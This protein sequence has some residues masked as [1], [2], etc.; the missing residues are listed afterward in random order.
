MNIIKPKHTVLQYPGGQT[1]TWLE[2]GTDANGEFLIVEHILNRT[3]AVNG[4]HWHPILSETFSIEQG[5]IRFKVD[6]KE[7]VL[8]PGGKVTIL[9]GQVHQF[10]NE[11]ADP[12]IMIHEI[13]PPGLHWH[14]FSLMHKL[15]SEG[16]LNRKGIPRNPLWIGLAWEA[17]D[18][19]LAGPPIPIQKIV[20][21]SLARLAKALG[22]KI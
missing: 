1:V 18:G 14:M 12:L 3:G 20:F 8:G 15:E 11:G 6:G 22:Y 10:W 9:P 2:Q 21:G 16:K 7:T 4:P 5:T 13:R 17:M 19:Y